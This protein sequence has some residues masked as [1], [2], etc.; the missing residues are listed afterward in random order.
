MLYF[1]RTPLR[2]VDGTQFKY[3]DFEHMMYARLV[4]RKS[5]RIELNGFPD[6]VE[7]TPKDFLYKEVGGIWK[8]CDRRVYIQAL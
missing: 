8:L 4:Y 7:I 3:Y 6:R 2:V 5:T 1:I